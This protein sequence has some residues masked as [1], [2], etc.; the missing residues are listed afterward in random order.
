MGY[1]AANMGTSKQAVGRYGEYNKPTRLHYICGVSH[2]PYW[3]RTRREATGRHV[4]ITQ[5]HNTI[6]IVVYS[7]NT[8]KYSPHL[9]KMC[10]A[11]LMSTTFG[12]SQYLNVCHTT[13]TTT[14][15][16]LKVTNWFVKHNHTALRLQWDSFALRRRWG[17]TSYKYMIISKNTT[18]W[19]T[20][21]FTFFLHLLSFILLLQC[22]MASSL[23][24]TN[25]T[26]RMTQVGMCSLMAVIKCNLPYVRLYN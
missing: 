22:V 3:W 7:R 4:F 23:F 21:L 14:T 6:P 5:S 12:A 10:L 1:L 15:K 16:W 26:H 18:D 17:Q 9:K 25:F 24:N 19:E 13:T 11:A 2:G 8:W 20:V